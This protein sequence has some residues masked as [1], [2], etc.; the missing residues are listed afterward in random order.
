MRIAGA[1]AVVGLAFAMVACGGDGSAAAAGG[2]GDTGTGNP[3]PAP[4]SSPT[5]SSTATSIAC[6][7]DGAQSFA[8]TCSVERVE[9][10]GKI[11]LTVFHPDG[12]FRRFEQLPDGSGLAAVAGADAVTQTL[13]GDILEVSLAGNRYRFPATPR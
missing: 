1:L 7:P 10:E 4:T 12:G 11:L 5:G 13:S 6:A 2:G 8:A 9:V 3:D